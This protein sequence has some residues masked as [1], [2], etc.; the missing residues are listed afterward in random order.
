MLNGECQMPKAM[1]NA[2]SNAFSAFGIRHSA[3]GIRHSTFDIRHSQ[4]SLIAPLRRLHVLAM[5]RFLVER[6]LHAHAFELPRRDVREVTV[7]SERLSLG[8]LALLA[9]VAA[10]RFG[11]LERVEG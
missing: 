8:R 11:A 3:F 2:K 5:E 7:V 10:A 6:R 9:E 4:F 1:P